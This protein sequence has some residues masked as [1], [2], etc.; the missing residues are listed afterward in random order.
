M[1]CCVFFLRSRLSSNLW[2]ENQ[3]EKTELQIP[4][5]DITGANE[6]GKK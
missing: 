6:D 2:T 5:R 3:I 4:S 1:Q